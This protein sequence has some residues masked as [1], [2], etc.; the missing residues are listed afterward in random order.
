MLER[1][2]AEAREA[3]V[4]LVLTVCCILR[5]PAELVGPQQGR[6]LAEAR[7]AQVVCSVSLVALGCVGVDQPGGLGWGTAW[8]DMAPPKRSGF[9]CGVG[10]VSAARKLWLT[11]F[12]ILTSTAELPWSSSFAAGRAVP[13]QPA[14]HRH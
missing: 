10:M 4:G 6:Q 13:G 1:Q 11:V 12:I 2:L 9:D 3:Q 8:I 5:Q 14:V 7:K